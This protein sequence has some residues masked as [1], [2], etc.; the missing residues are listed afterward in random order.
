MLNTKLMKSTNG[1][2]WDRIRVH[3]DKIYFVIFHAVT[4]PVPNDLSEIIA[5]KWR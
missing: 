5:T 4:T 3:I 2:I 1:F